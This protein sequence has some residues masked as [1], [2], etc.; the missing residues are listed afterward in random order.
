M[1]SE[2]GLAV[3]TLESFIIGFESVV[4]YCSES[5]SFLPTSFIVPADAASA[6]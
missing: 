2:S 6:A 1:A 4:R 5:F 3:A